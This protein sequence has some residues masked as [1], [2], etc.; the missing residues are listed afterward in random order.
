MKLDSK[1]LYYVQILDSALPVGTF[2]HSFGLETYVQ[3]N[4]IQTIKELKQFIH[5][6][7]QSSILPFEGLAM[8]GIY[9]ALQEHNMDQLAYYNHVLLVQRTARESR[10]AIAKMGKRLWQLSKTIHPWIDFEPLSKSVP[11][12]HMTL[13]TMHTFIAYDLSITLDETVKGYAYTNVVTLINS[14]IR[15]M[16]LGQTDGQHI[17]QEMIPIIHSEWEKIK[18]TP[19]SEMHSFAIAQE[20]EAMNHET[21]YSRLFMS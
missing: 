20:I 9:G 8:K 16:S 7:L 6:Q 21:L 3:E 10:E 5:S 12:H 4:K 18:E 11:N 2:S 17:I 19:S 1:L 14:A 15:L 13:P